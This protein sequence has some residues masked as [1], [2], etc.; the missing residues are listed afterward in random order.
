MDFK[1][2]EHLLIIQLKNDIK[3]LILYISKKY[4]KQFTKD[5][6]IKLIEEYTQSI[7]LCEYSKNSKNK[8]NT[9]VKKAIFTRKFR[10]SF[11]VNTNNI[12]FDS[13]K[14]CARVW[15]NGSIIKTEEGKII[16]GKQCSRSRSKTS[17]KYC[18]HHEKNNPHGDF[19]KKPSKDMKL[20][21]KKEGSFDKMF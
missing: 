13:K 11:L 17:K 9:K 5:D 15:N 12:S 19:N 14:C 3:N 7:N 8:I 20:H 6:A 4:S 18:Y 2:I 16:Y 1:H 21:Y 10:N